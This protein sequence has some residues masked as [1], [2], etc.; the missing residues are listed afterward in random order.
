MEKSIRVTEQTD[1]RSF[2]SASEMKDVLKNYRLDRETILGL[3]QTGEEFLRIAAGGTPRTGNFCSIFMG[4]FG[5]R[6]CN[7]TT[8][9]S[10]CHPDRFATDMSGT[11]TR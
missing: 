8:K 6:R 7:G 4:R 1:G 9:T 5:S 2:P 11:E 3:Q 10:C